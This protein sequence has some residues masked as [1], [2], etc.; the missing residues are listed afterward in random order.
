MRLVGVIPAAGY[1]TRLKRPGGSKEVYRVGGRPLIDYEIGRMRL[2]PI[3]ELRVVTRP[4]KTDVIEYATEQHGAVIVKG[5]PP[6]LA[7]SFYTG[8]RALAD[9]DVALLGFPDSL[10][11]PEPNDGY[12]DVVEFFRSGSWDV[13][14]GLLPA[15]DMRREEPVLW[16]PTTG[17]VSSLEFKPEHPSA[18]RTWAC[19]VAS[20]R[21]LRGLESFEEAGVFFNSLCR[22][23]RVGALPLA[24]EFIDMGTAR[25]LEHALAAL[26]TAAV[27]S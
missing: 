26:E 25:G 17:V 21:V 10:W 1:G 19:A 5:H 4:E 9:D 15:P 16:D 6:C 24:G 8:I 14:L 22:S 13:A 27:A 2:A 3:D 11:W 12:R 23:G 7:Q 18:D 20:V